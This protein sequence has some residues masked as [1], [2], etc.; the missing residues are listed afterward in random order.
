MD[1]H[2]T[3]HLVA[4]AAAFLHSIRQPGNERARFYIYDDGTSWDTREL[5]PEPS[6]PIR[7]ILD[8]QHVGLPFDGIYAAV[9]D[10]LA[11]PTAEPE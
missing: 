7:M 10:G 1:Q 5:G 11:K 9:L 3:D 8:A 4:R 2:A 6:K